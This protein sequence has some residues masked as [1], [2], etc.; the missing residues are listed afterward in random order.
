MNKEKSRM[1]I[2]YIQYIDMIEKLS[3]E[4]SKELILKIADFCTRILDI[5]LLANNH[6]KR[7]KDNN[8]DNI[9]VVEKNNL[10]TPIYN[11]GNKIDS[12][13]QL[14]FLVNKC[15]K[16]NSIKK[17]EKAKINN[18]NLLDEIRKDYNSNDEKRRKEALKKLSKLTEEEFAE[19]YTNARYE[20]RKELFYE[21]KHK[22]LSAIIKEFG[23]HP[24]KYEEYIYGFIRDNDAYVFAINIPGNLG[25][26]QF[27]IEPNDEKDILYD[28]NCYEIQHEFEQLAE[29]NIELG[30]MSF[31]YTKEELKDLNKIHQELDQLKIKAQTINK[32]ADK[33]QEEIFRKI[34]L[35]SI[36]L[37]KNTRIELNEANSKVAFSF[38]NENEC[39]LSEYTKERTIEDERKFNMIIRNLKKF[40]KIYVSSPNTLDSK[41]AIESLRRKCKDIG[42]DLE[43]ENIIPIAPGIKPIEQGIYLNLNKNGSNFN[44]NNQIFI[45]VNEEKRELSVSS[46]L[47]RLGF[48]VPRDVV[49]YANRADIVSNDPNNAYTLASTG[50]NG[51]QIYDLCEELK[52]SG[53]DL[54]SASL[55]DE[56]ID[57]YDV[58]Q[59]KIDIEDRFKKFINQIKY[60]QVGNKIVAIYDGDD[61]MASYFAYN[62]GA[63]YVISVSDY[64]VEN[65]KKGVTF[66]IQSD[67]KKDD[68]PFEVIKWALQTK[69]EEL[70]KGA[71]PQSSTGFKNIDDMLIK[72]TRI[73]CGGNNRPDLY[74]ED[75]RENKNIEF[76]DQITEQIIFQIAISEARN[77]GLDYTE[78]SCELSDVK[79]I[80]KSINMKAKE[81]EQ[82]K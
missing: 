53:A 28:I 60:Q 29:G 55:T 2:P 34:F 75:R 41:V 7:F 21:I 54:K 57:R 13:I 77:L 51:K 44:H 62:N 27:H 49:L 46:I 78:L 12:M 80:V 81:L 6:E 47:Y 1:Y 10:L 66:A 68:L 23:S 64:C 65:E 33:N 38:I 32:I 17:E 61:P 63:H 19:Y 20:N 50:M 37:G 59:H 67:P 25:T 22:L 14:A 40:G 18:K 35:Y 79:S 30:K 48:D 74:L 82:D 39:R 42:F 16:P 43:D 11:A 70:L 15:T 72:S 52:E 5:D 69:R 73:I 45:N 76:K 26:Y 56:Q 58:R 8:G 3:D 9:I 24:E 4:T 31:L 71:P 36:L